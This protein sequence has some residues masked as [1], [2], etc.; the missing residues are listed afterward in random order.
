MADFD[1]TLGGFTFQSFEVPDRIAFG[2]DQQTKVH[3][4]VGGQR[5]IDAMGRDDPDL[6]WEGRFTGPD[7]LSRALQLKAM[8]AAGG[9][10]ALAWS[11]L[12]YTVVLKSFQP[13][14]EKPFLIPYRITLEVQADNS[15]SVGAAATPSLDD[16]LGSDF[17]DASDY[18]DVISDPTLSG[19]LSNLG[20][21]LSSV[22]TFVGAPRAVLSSATTPLG[23]AQAQ[24]N[25]LIFA[26]E[27]VTGGD[28]TGDAGT[29]AAFVTG[30]AGAFAA[31]TP[32]YGAQSSLGRIATNLS[33][34]TTAGAKQTQAGG[35]LYAVAAQAYADPGQ[36]PVIA[37]ANGLVDPSLSG[38]NT[39]TIPPPQASTDGVL[40]S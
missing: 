29:L 28:F 23:Q 36:W 17:D 22:S 18:G 34:V 15:A 3:K 27:A 16:Q 10:L 39:L 13:D 24:V 19:S 12:S 11:E 5:T 8:A 30:Q 20:S 1:L 2:A 26:G 38:I 6:T 32:L 7:A 33:D 40:Q 21:A 35:N 9:A 37:Q 14:F 25:T 4:L 31:L